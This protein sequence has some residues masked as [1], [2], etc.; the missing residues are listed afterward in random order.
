[1]GN[2]DLN[3]YTM[4][5]LGPVFELLDKCKDVE[6]NKKWH[7]EGDVFIHSMQVFH[8]AIKET[9][10]TDLILAAL[11]HDVGKQIDSKAHDMIALDMLDDYCSSKTIWL[12]KEHM[13]IW[14]YLEGEMR[15]RS[16]CA[17]L[18]KHPWL[19]ELI[20]L[21]RWDK[22][23]RREHFKPKYTYDDILDILNVKAIKHFGEKEEQTGCE[24]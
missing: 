1:M 11:L 9:D 24:Q 12:I 5:L 20:Q 6:Q 13:R 18:V 4:E 8:Y 19:M 7:P 10:D 2:E 16:K 14:Y 15:R 3:L 23:G 21:A 17:K 22:M